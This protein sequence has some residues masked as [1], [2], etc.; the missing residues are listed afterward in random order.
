M[1]KKTNKFSA[2]NLKETTEVPKK[3]LFI[4]KENFKW[5]LIGLALSS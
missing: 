1:S 2:D 3:I 4:S 5:M